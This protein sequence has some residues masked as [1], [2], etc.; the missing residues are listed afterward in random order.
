MLR[1]IASGKDKQVDAI[2]Q[3]IAHVDAD[4]LVL[5]DIDYDHGSIALS[6]LAKRI[7]G[8]PHH[9]ARA[10]NRG[11]QS[12]YDLNGDDRFGRPSDAWGYGEFTGQGG[13]AV[14]SKHPIGEVVDF[15]AA[16]W[17]AQE[18][19][20]VLPDAPP[21][22]PLSTTAHWE[23]PVL[24]PDGQRVTL[25]TWHAT[26]PVFDGPE[27]RNGRRNHDE[28]A[29]WLHRIKDTQPQNLVIA[30]F[31]NLDPIDGDGRPAALDALLAHPALTDPRPAS[32][33]AVLAGA[34]DTT[35]R[36][37]AKLDT[38]DWPTEGPG[39]LRVDYVLPSSDL[40][41]TDAGVFWPTPDQLL[42]DEVVAASRHRMVW[43]DIRVPDR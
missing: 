28:A 8:Y 21:E 36:G 24:L 3:V 31:A 10:P 40:Q 6:A 35:H 22:H 26:A 34:V 37:L 12:G 32:E 42:G 39:N 4:V 5:G 29:F 19:A 43:V 13:L 41:V 7:G 30:G 1:A 15:S 33:G 11:L 2:A 17:R 16:L 23:V 25:L 20:L 38:V 27:D 14:L 18:D 9:F